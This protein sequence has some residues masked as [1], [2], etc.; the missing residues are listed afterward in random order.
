MYGY[1]YK[2]INCVNGKIY[3][4][5]KKSSTFLGEQYLGS[6]VRL[7][8][9]IQH[10]GIDKFKVE[11]LDIADNKE[12]LDHK[13]TFW[14]S[15]LNSQSPDIGYNIANGGDGGDTF[16]QHDD[17][18]KEEIIA[19]IKQSLSVSDKKGRVCVTKD[20]INKYVRIDVLDEF[21]N[22]GWTKGR[23]DLFKHKSGYKQT[24][25]WVNK[26]IKSVMNRTAEQKAHTSNLHSKSTKAQMEKLTV[27]QRSELGRKARCA[28]LNKYP[29]E[30]QFWIH[31]DGINKLIFPSEYN[32]YA[33]QGYVKGMYVSEKSKQTR[34][35]SC[36]QAKHRC[37]HVYLYKEDLCISIDSSDLDNYLSDGWSKGNLALRGIKK[38]RKK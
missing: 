8:S 23:V 35:E 30:K 11:L 25:E 7:R 38:C 16:T 4:G 3:V 13:E 20:G 17:F 31:R 10:Y 28:R 33:S 19:K 22:D 9:A 1:I 14:I 27:E 15:E 21:I 29:G 5:Q 24:D 36:K 6:G 34:S 12:Q 2:T 37:G 18:E 26:R 32:D